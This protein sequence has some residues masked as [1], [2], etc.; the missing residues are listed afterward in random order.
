M[1]INTQIQK[2]I[3][4]QLEAPKHRE[5]ITEWEIGQNILQEL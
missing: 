4:K 1:Y 2:Q 5:V 3:P